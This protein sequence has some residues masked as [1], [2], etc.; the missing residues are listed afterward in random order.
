LGHFSWPAHFL[1][2]PAHHPQ[3][4]SHC[5]AHATSFSF[6]PVTLTHGSYLSASGHSCRLRKHTRCLWTPRVWGVPILWSVP[7]PKARSSPA[8]TGSTGWMC[9]RAR[10]SLLAPARTWAPPGYK[11]GG[12]H[13]QTMVRREESRGEGEN[14]MPN[15]PS[16]SI[17]G[18]MAVRSM[19]IDLWASPG[20]LDRVSADCGTGGGP[21]RA[22]FVAA[23]AHSRF[24]VDRPKR[25]R[26]LGKDLLLWFAFISISFCT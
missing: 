21:E 23:I 13:P 4:L 6:L 10:S 18:P 17:Q 3:I 26:V 11:F 5:S 15:A 8:L 12:V 1:H 7:Q 24:V 16:P 14:G 25:R 2:A 20:S 22:Q 9:S 19:K